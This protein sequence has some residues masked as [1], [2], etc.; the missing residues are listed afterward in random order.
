MSLD[1]F[2]FCFRN[3][4]LVPFRRSIVVGAWAP[5]IKGDDDSTEWELTF[6]DGGRAEIYLDEGPEINHFMISRPGASS[7]FWEG[8]F[9]I[10]EETGSILLNTGDGPSSFIT[11]E[12]FLRHYPQEEPFIPSAVV[13]SAEE[14]RSYFWIYRPR[15]D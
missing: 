15:D 12:I 11:D 8:L 13:T 2:L 7:A 1:L 10:M 3:G 5:F 9:L 4:E 6:P 14:L